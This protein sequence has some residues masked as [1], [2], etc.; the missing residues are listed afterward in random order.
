[1]ITE[2]SLRLLLEN[3][4]IADAKQKLLAK[5]LKK[6]IEEYGF[7]VADKGSSMENYDRK[8][9]Y[10]WMQLTPIRGPIYQKYGTFMRVEINLNSGRSKLVSRDGSVFKYSVPREL[11]ELCRKFKHASQDNFRTTIGKYGSKV[12]K[13]E[14]MIDREIEKARN[15]EKYQNLVKKTEKEYANVVNK[16][17]KTKSGNHLTPEEKEKLEKEKERLDNKLE[18]LN[19]GLFVKNN[20]QA[21][22][23][24]EALRKEHIKNTEIAKINKGDK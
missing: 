17:Y 20:F 14:Q 19:G 16:L 6:K 21:N 23:M 3:N 2:K 1:M 9:Y 12:N 7:E 4:D 5:D 13:T 10:N 15:N 11:V 24:R 22:R 18:T 8:K